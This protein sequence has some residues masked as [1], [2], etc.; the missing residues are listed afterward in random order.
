M[1]IF[2]IGGMELVII[3]VIML[4]VAGPQRMIRWAYIMGQYTAKLRRMWEE[5]A[6]Y[7][8]KEFDDAGLDVEVP[9]DIP[10]RGSINQAVT[11]QLNKAMTPVTKPIQDTVDEVKKSTSLSTSSTNGRANGVKQAT[12][13]AASPSTPS[14][15]PANPTST[16][17]SNATPP[18][19]TDFGAWS[20]STDAED[21]GT[22][23]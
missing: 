6:S 7:L 14:A 19:N 4:V 23:P 5:T 11:K 3:L 18:A 9:K 21:K 10:T 16:S 15:S 17:T 20:G 8:Q 1:N 22:P 13:P 2:G 12:T